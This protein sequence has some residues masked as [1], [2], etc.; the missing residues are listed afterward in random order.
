MTATEFLRERKIVPKDK[1]DL[2]IGFDNGT[3]ESLIELLESYVEY[4]L[5]NQLKPDVMLSLPL[6]EILRLDQPWPL[7][8]VLKKLI[9]ASDI[10][11]H[12]KN[13]D[14]NGWEEHEH[15]FREGNKI[16]ELL[17]GNLRE[18]FKSLESNK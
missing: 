1:T 13:Y 4:K 16:V 12:E 17:K 3:K 11:L 18:R 5:N 7:V 2:I 14:R 10:L 9:E 8:D 6:N 15:C